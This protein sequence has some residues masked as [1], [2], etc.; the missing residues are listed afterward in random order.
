[1]KC[2]Q[3]VCDVVQVIKSFIRYVINDLSKNSI[4]ETIVQ[5]NFTSM[6][7]R[8]LLLYKRSRFQLSL[9]DGALVVRVRFCRT[10]IVHLHDPS[11]K[12]DT[13]PGFPNRPGIAH[14]TSKYFV[15]ARATPAPPNVPQIQKIVARNPYPCK[16]GRHRGF[17]LVAR[18]GP[19]KRKRTQKRQL[20]STRS[21]SFIARLLG[22]LHST[23]GYSGFHHVH[24]SLH[25]RGLIFTM[26]AMV[27]CTEMH[28]YWHS[29]VLW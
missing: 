10:C 9:G 7:F 27:S 14:N 26:M 6:A 29:N 24:N 25:W 15:W 13:T 16:L 23:A 18:V 12:T 4:R 28:L 11:I 1:M 5:T 2:I 20:L 17:L 22:Q 19:Q 21:A 3:E 8:L